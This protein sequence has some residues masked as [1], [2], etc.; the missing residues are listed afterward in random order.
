MTAMRAVNVREGSVAQRIGLFLR[1]GCFR[2]RDQLLTSCTSHHKIPFAR[3]GVFSHPAGGSAEPRPA[4]PVT[5]ARRFCIH[6]LAPAIGSLP[7]TRP[8]SYSNR[9]QAQR[10]IAETG[11]GVEEV[12]AIGSSPVVINVI[13]DA[14]WRAFRIAHLDMRNPG[15]GLARH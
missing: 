10:Q 9:L 5:A 2:K 14:L 1:R 15:A 11:R 12:D 8:M 4:S 6:C 7:A 3:F 13:I